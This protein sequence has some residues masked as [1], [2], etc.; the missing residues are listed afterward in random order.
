[1]L[2]TGM[3]VGGWDKYE[4]GQIYSV[5]LGGTILKQP[6]TIGGLYYTS[7]HPYNHKQTNKNTKHHPDQAFNSRILLAY[8]IFFCLLFSIYDFTSNL[9][10]LCDCANV[11]LYPAILFPC[12]YQVDFFFPRR[13]VNVFDTSPFLQLIQLDRDESVP[14]LYAWCSD[15]VNKIIFMHSFAWC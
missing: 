13:D 9:L 11:P 14:L 2:Q 4:G 5:P 15:P 6:F 7:T 12:L 3:I 8:F 10:I 1:M